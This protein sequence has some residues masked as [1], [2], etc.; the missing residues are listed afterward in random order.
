MSD[1]DVCRGV[2]VG[3][4]DLVDVVRRLVH[5]SVQ[6]AVAPSSTDS[7]VL[8]LIDDILVLTSLQNQSHLLP[9]LPPLIVVDCFLKQVNP[10]GCYWV[11]RYCGLNMVFLKELTW[12]VWV[13]ICFKLFG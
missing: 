11:S 1:V 5:C 7:H 12:W 2:S 4:R 3:C 13:L 10:N 6:L 9:T 8:S